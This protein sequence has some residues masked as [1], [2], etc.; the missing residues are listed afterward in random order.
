M[1]KK[2]TILSLLISTLFL[3][4]CAIGY[5]VDKTFTPLSTVNCETT[6]ENVT[7]FFE[8]EKVDFEYEKI[9]LIE[10]QGEYSST[11][12]ELIEE[13][14]KMAKSKCCD[15]VINLKKS[16][17]DRDKKLLFTDVPDE[18]YTSIVYNGIAVRK[19]K[20]FQIK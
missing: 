9:G 17:V 19:N 11:D 7:L 13:V 8:G 14:K 3:N 18:K 20:L 5:S 1:I 12:A 4:S 16:Y 10:I 2:T 15:I 6:P